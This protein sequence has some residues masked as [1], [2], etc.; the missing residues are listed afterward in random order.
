MVIHMI[1][2]LVEY[3]DDSSV[4]MDGSFVP[5]R[6]EIDVDKR[7]R[8]A[9]TRRSPITVAVSPRA[10][11]VKRGY[12]NILQVYRLADRERKAFLDWVQNALSGVPFQH[13]SCSNK[14][15]GSSEIA[16]PPVLSV[17]DC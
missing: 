2:L 7:S 16:A 15:Q 4:I 9:G 11:R 13:I 12:E 3:C 14:A 1:S 6:F 5:T 17:Q 10:D 8:V